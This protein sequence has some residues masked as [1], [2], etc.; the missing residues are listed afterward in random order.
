[1]VSGRS[2]LK[3]N[4]AQLRTVIGAMMFGIVSFAVVVIIVG[5]TMTP[6]PSLGWILCGFLGLLGAAELGAYPLIRAGFVKM[7]KSRHERMALI[8]TSPVNSV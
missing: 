8:S 1:M 3:L 5:R 7:A 6:N 4:L 2:E